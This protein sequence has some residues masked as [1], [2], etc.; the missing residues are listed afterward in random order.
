M[1]IHKKQCF[2]I[3]MLFSVTAASA[4]IVNM[5]SNDGTP[6]RVGRHD[7]I[8]GS[9]YYFGEHNWVDGTLYMADGRVYEKMK[10]RYNGFDDEIEYLKDGVAMVVD[11]YDLKGFDLVFNKTDITEKTRAYEFKNGFF[12]EGKIMKTEFFSVIY[13]G[14]AIALVEKFEVYKNELTPDT[15]GGKG[16][17]EFEN[18]KRAYLIYGEEVHGFKYKK[19]DFYKIFSDK[20][21]EIKKFIKINDLDMD[22]RNH[23]VTLLEYVETDLID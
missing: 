15:Y 2:L 11:N 23:L 9:P 1:Q 21:E 3:V 18:R 10:I 7:D 4:Q 16:I 6:L 20:A 5:P 14:D 22:N 12:I 19:R 13:Q 17:E 8:G